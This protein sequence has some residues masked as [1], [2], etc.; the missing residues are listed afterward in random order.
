V[1]LVDRAGTAS[2][3]LRSGKPSAS[4]LAEVLPE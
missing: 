4:M 2:K 3:L 1:K